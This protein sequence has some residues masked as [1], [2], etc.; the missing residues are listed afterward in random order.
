MTQFLMMVSICAMGAATYLIVPF[1]DAAGSA[2]AKQTVK[3]PAK[4]TV[5]YKGE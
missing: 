2:R 5:R 3:V 4:R 1:I